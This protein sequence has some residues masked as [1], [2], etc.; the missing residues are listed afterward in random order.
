MAETTDHGRR[1]TGAPMR[2]AVFASGGG[3]NFASMLKA[4]DAGRLTNARTGRVL[5]TAR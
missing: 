5:G 3:S 1:T 4:I 2:L